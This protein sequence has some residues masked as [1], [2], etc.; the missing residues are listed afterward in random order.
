MPRTYRRKTSWGSTPL[1][2]IERAASEVKGGKSIRS[3]ATERQI[4]RSTLRRYIKKRDTQEVK[5]VGYSGTASAKR[6]FSEEV[7]KELAEHIKKLAEQ[8]HGI[9]PKKCRELALELAGRNNIPTPSNWTEKGLA[10]KEWFKNFLARHHLSCRMP[11]ATS[12]GRATAFN[13]TTVGEFFDNLAKVID[14]YK[15][16]P[17]MIF[18]V[19]KTGVT[20]VQTPK[21]VV[22]EKGKKQVGS[23]TS[24][25]RGELVTVVCAVNA[26]GNVSSQGLDAKTTSLQEHLRDQLVPL[27][28]QAGSVKMSLLCSL[29]I[30][31]SRP[32]APLTCHCC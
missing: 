15:F 28:D 23:I 16:P 17:N 11:E 24:A 27:Q 25:E 9:S 22:A 12:L 19:D 6:V 1:E 13:K 20:T 7:E 30:W 3:V 26:T 14:R 31:F 29:N 5:S 8:F 2:E 21:Q 4:D 32:S 18:N 10:G